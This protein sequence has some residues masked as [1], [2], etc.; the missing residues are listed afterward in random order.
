MIA[1]SDLGR[2]RVAYRQ[3]KYIKLRR[4]PRIRIGSLNQN[5][6]RRVFGWLLVRSSG[7]QK[8]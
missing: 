7:E 4:V 5:G 3:P 6:I 1:G 8:S 2:G